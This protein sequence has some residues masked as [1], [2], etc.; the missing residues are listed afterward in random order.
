MP[1]GRVRERGGKE[2][3]VTAPR[4]SSRKLVYLKKPSIPRLNTTE[5]VRKARQAPLLC[6]CFSMPLLAIKSTRMEAIIM[7][8]Y[9]T[10]PQE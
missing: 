4:F 8:K 3:P 5:R 10:S 7:G 1:R 6:R 2:S 9:R